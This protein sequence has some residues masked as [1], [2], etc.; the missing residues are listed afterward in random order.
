[1]PSIQRDHSHDPGADDAS[2]L[3]IPAIE[4]AVQV[5]ARARRRVAAIAWNSIGRLAFSIGR[6]AFSIGR[7]EFN[8]LG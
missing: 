5:G 7:L 1:V 2:V 3:S 4:V 8:G 6:L